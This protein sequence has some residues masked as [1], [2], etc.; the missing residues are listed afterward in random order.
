MGSG[1]DTVVCCKYFGRDARA[2][3]EGSERSSI[4]GIQRDACVQHRND[5]RRGHDSALPLARLEYF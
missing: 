3:A 5:N 1:E 2:C 4:Q